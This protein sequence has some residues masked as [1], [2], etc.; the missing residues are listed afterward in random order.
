M[1]PT[2]RFFSTS[3]SP[4]PPSVR[5]TVQIFAPLLILPDTLRNVSSPRLPPPPLFVF[6]RSSCSDRPSPCSP[7]VLLWKLG[8]SICSVHFP[9]VHICYSCSLV[10]VYAVHLSPSLYC[11]VRFDVILAVDFLLWSFVPDFSFA[12]AVAPSFFP[13][14]KS[15]L[16]SF[17][18]VFYF[19]KAHVLPHRMSSAGGFPVPAV[20]SLDDL[21]R[22][23]KSGRTCSIL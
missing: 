6:P 1:L 12:H 19:L 9:L 16:F 5:N 2:A 23:L 10:S 7:V 4:R 13:S 15:L 18:S 8:C 20:I 11:R 17:F 3:P 14:S 22:F 21:F